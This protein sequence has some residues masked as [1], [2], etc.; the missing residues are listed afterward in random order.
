LYDCWSV[1]KNIDD[2]VEN[3]EISIE[4]WD[5]NSNEDRKCDISGEENIG[6]EG[7]D[8]KIDYNIKTGQWN[9]DDFIGDNSGYGRLCG[10]DDGSIY[11]HEYDCEIWFKIYQ[12]DYDNDGL[13]YYEEEYIYGTNPEIS[14]I[15]EDSDN[16]GLPIEWEDFW[17]YNPILWENHEELDPDFDSINNSE[18]FLTRDFKSD[19]FRQDIFLEMDFMLDKDGKQ[20][21]IPELTFELLQDPYNRRNIVFHT[22]TGEVEGGEVL[23]FD[24]NTDY[25]ELIEIHN[26][27]FLHNDI[28]NWRRGV[29][30]Y[31]IVVYYRKPS[32]A[33]SGDTKPHWGYF[34]GTNSFVISKSNPDYYYEYYNQEK[35]MAYLYAANFM[36]EMGHNFG[37]RFGKP[38]GC[39]HFLSSQPWMYGYWLYRN[40]KSIM[41]YR[42]IFEIFDYSN[43]TNG[44]R[45]YND[46]GKLDLFYFERSSKTITNFK[47]NRLI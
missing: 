28:S 14:N 36:H 34:G 45:D 5:K 2:N 39:D 41:N 6:S 38:M 44:K 22:D 35:S 37:I 26:N 47:I 25:D 33:F 27:F 7:F 1:N 40:Y 4:L 16:D 21:Q 19:P 12:T 8:I 23:P 15:A 17:G 20:I 11:N 10:C 24:N 18:E 43:G 32:M 9:G 46:W 3:V 30:H 13:T 42:Y 31:G 29:F